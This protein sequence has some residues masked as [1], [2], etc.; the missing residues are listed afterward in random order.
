MA[1]KVNRDERALAMWESARSEWSGVASHR[2]T[3]VIEAHKFLTDD[4]MWPRA[5]RDNM[6]RAK[7]PPLVVPELQSHI[8]AVSGREATQRYQTIAKPRNP[9]EPDAYWSQVLTEAQ[10]MLFQRTS[11]E[12][13]ISDAFRD[14]LIGGI[15]WISIELDF[16]AHAE[17]ELVIKSEPP[18]HVM[19]DPH[20]RRQNIEDA[21][22][23]A[24][25]QWT[26]LELAKIRWPK[27]DLDA[28]SALDFGNAVGSDMGGEGESH[29][30][31]PIDQYRDRGQG[32]QTDSKS[33]QRDLRIVHFQW[34]EQEDFMLHEDLTGAIVA[35]SADRWPEVAQAIQDQTGEMPAAFP[36]K[37]R[38]VWEAFI[39]GK[40]VLEA[41]PCPVNDFTLKAITGFPNKK[42]DVTEWYGLVRKAKDVQLLLNRLHSL[43]VHLLASSAKD[44]I[45]AEKGAF[46]DWNEAQMA[47]AQPGRILQANPQAVVQKRFMVERAPGL[48]PNVTELMK[49]AGDLMPRATGVNMY[50][51]GQ[52]EDLRR[53]A[54][55]AVQ[56]VERAGQTVL[57]IAF[58]SLRRFRIGL[59]EHVARWIYE[60]F[61][62]QDLARML[63][64]E[65]AQQ[66]PP[67]AVWPSLNRWDVVIDEAPSSPSE[68]ER[69]WS[70][71]H[72]DIIGQLLMD[73]MTAPPPDVKIDMLPPG[74]PAEL[75]QRWKMHLQMMAQMQQQQEQPPPD[76][77]AQE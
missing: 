30:N 16:E 55:T 49:L 45:I 47:F 32:V 72:H 66:V 22:W 1:K 28:S 7:A 77:A 43:A 65:L 38:R 19:Y 37:S 62:E 12:H 13:E 5:D 51:L 17:G 54:N 21:R 39:C 59:G 27:A 53:T 6:E 4:A 61:D 41:R 46:H 73:P 42:K 67:K 34:F 3:A 40:T 50:M 57:A 33:R 18:F 76:G 75:R 31:Y 11:A 63:S 23:V 9:A 29:A 15:G 64:P 74:L 10:R 35:T 68:L 69:F 24:R 26:P 48:S 36:R 20:A 44:L 60:M 25:Q 52:V 70:N 14:M 2:T 56:S 8:D 58:D 71:D